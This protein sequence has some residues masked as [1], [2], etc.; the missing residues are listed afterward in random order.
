LFTQWCEDVF[1]GEVFSWGQAASVAVLLSGIFGLALYNLQN[2][3]PERETLNAALG[4]ALATG[5]F[6]ALYTTYDAY[7]IRASTDP[8]TFVAWLFVIDS[9]SMPI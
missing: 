4:F 6:V 8:F 7:G 3:K 5:G 9:W 2:L 1:F